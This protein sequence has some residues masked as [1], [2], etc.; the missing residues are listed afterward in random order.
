MRAWAE[1]GRMTYQQKTREHL[2]WHAQ[3][4]R[5]DPDSFCQNSL[6]ARV[7]DFGKQRH[8]QL[9]TPSW[10]LTT[11]N[12]AQVGGRS[13]KRSL[14]HPRSLCDSP[15]YQLLQI[16]FD[17]FS[18]MSLHRA[19]LVPTAVEKTSG[20]EFEK[21]QELLATFRESSPSFPSRNS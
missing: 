9:T 5:L 12:F 1:Q 19:A 10:S 21:E 18:I 7:R 20:V 4:K 13:Q 14:T 17:C 2:S 11:A 3:K 8:P 6:F 16:R 15:K